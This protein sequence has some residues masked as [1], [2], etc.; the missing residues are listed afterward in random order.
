MQIPTTVRKFL[1]H[2]GGQYKVHAAPPGL[3]LAATVRAAGVPVQQLVRAS[4]LTD[5][6][7]YLMAVYPATQQ[8][9]P[10]ALPGYAPCSR[11]ELAV[12]LPDCDPAVLPPLGDAYG[13]RLVVDPAVDALEVVYFFAGAGQL[14]VRAPAEDFL[15]LTAAARRG[16]PLTRGLAAA[17]VQPA[18]PS[19]PL[20]PLPEI[21]SRLLELR[22]D[23]YAHANAL[24]A[25]IAQDQDLAAQLRL[26]LATPLF[27]HQDTMLSLEQG[28][29]RVLGMDFV[30]DFALA[31]VL[32]RSFSRAGALP[33][34]LE[35][36]WYDALHVAALTQT[37]CEAIEYSRRPSPGAAYTAGLL[38]NVG[39][40]LLGYRFPQGFT[41]LAAARQSG[42][43]QGELEQE[44]FGT[45]AVE[46]GVWLANVWNLPETVAVTV[47]EHRNVTYRGDYAVYPHLV[48]LANRLLQRCGIGDAGDGELPEELLAAVGLEPAQAEAALATVLEMREG[49]QLMAGKMAA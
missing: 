29:V 25:L 48:H 19:A 45:T 49:L 15:R 11:E 47:R 38:H 17:G 5:G 13:L 12:L 14:F 35:H 23:P 37:L 20:P 44:L 31:L 4:V 42:R 7:S 2:K 34:G 8:L 10:A 43:P 18:P 9:D 3:P 26:Y 6:G 32:G 16:Q 28:I 40:L 30:T 41:R 46:Q 27:G 21:A 36:F 22:S 24:A 33:A 1:A 39:L